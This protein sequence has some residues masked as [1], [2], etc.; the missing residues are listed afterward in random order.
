MSHRIRYLSPAFEDIGKIC[1][2]LAR[3]SPA[4][5]PRWVD[6]MENAVRSLRHMPHRCPLAPEDEFFPMEIRQLRFDSYRVLFTIAGDEVRIIN[7]LHSARDTLP[8]GGDL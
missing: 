8:D 7:I 4:Y 3:H 5:A 6:R 2:Y 1:A